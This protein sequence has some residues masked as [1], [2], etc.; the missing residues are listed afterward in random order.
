MQVLIVLRT[1]SCDCN[2][3]RRV[4]SGWF[5]TASAICIASISGLVR[6]HMSLAASA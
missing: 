2:T 3:S 4:E 1:L 5:A 6:A